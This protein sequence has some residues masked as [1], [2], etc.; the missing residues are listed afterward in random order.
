[1]LNPCY[2]ALLKIHSA[3]KM[4][5][6]QMYPPKHCKQC[7]CQ[8]VLLKGIQQTSNSQALNHFNYPWGSNKS[9]DTMQNSRTPRRM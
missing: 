6:W 1:M 7:F 2:D 9:Y 3:H 4:S 5:V 8:Q